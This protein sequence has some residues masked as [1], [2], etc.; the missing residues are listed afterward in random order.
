[1]CFLSLFHRVLDQL[2]GVNQHLPVW[3]FSLFSLPFSLKMMQK[4]EKKT[5]NSVCVRKMHILT[6]FRARSTQK[7]V[8]IYNTAAILLCLPLL[9]SMIHFFQFLSISVICPSHC[10]WQNGFKLNVWDQRAK[11]S[12]K[13][14]THFLLLLLLCFAKWHQI[15]DKRGGHSDL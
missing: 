2:L 9:L 14:K 3:Y 7:L 1:M 8:E 6:S 5:T 15:K 13:T 11:A 10:V 12:N 4:R